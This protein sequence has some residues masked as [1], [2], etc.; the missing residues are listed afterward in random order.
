MSSIEFRKAARGDVTLLIDLLFE[1]HKL[2]KV[3]SPDRSRLEQMLLKLQEEPTHG[4]QFV[5]LNDG[6]P[7]GFATLFFLFS[8][9]FA[10]KVAILSDLF[11]QERFRN[12]RIGEQ[13]FKHCI[14][15]VKQSGYR[16]MD[17]VTL[18]DN[19][20]AKKFFEK[21]GASLQPYLL[22]SLDF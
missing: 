21:L 19:F 10:D 9:S 15:Y 1:Y 20:T 6:K 4:Q 11:I 12:Q 7:I 5:A 17:W 2:H 22:Y 16:H 18:Q 14:D 8:T 3:T 13:L